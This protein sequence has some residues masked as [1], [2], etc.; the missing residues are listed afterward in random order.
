MD[1]VSAVKSC[2]SKYVTFSGRAP[3][4]EYWFFLLFGLIAGFVTGILDAI[5]FG[6]Q[7]GQVKPI[8]GLLSLGML[9]P[10]IAVSVRRLHDINRSGWWL[11]LSMAALPFFFIFPPLATLMLLGIMVLF[12]IWY[13]TKGTTGPNRFGAD[14]LAA[15]PIA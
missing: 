9:L 4:S 3:R 11:L 12:L 13:C 10:S 1:F 6:I 8:N 14:P 2:F 5:L 15:T 7:P